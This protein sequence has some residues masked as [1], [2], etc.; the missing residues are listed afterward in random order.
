EIDRGMIG[1]VEEQ[2]L[3][4]ADQQ[5]S[6]DARRVWGKSAVEIEIEHVP[7][8]ADAAQHGAGELAHQRAVAVRKRRQARM[9][10][11]AL[12]LAVERTAAAQY[13]VEDVGGNAARGKTRD[14]R[15][16]C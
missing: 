1:H 5:H 3:R 16:S 4:G 13:I 2:D 11:R 8:G 14:L 10:I 9:L 6:L 7:Q 15:G 12:E